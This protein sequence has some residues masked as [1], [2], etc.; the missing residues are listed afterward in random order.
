MIKIQDIR[1]K[2]L[3]LQIKKHFPL[4]SPEKATEL[5]YKTSNPII[6]AD[7]NKDVALYMKFIVELEMMG[8]EINLKSS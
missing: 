5:Y 4:L 6:T 8:F 3:Q 7:I 2:L 1:T